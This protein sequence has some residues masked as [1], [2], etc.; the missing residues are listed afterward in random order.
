MS[1][2]PKSKRQ[3]VSNYPAGLIA[4]KLAGAKGAPFPEFI[5]PSLATAVPR[6]PSDSRWVHE[7]KFDGYRLQ[8]HL[9]AGQAT[10]YT[11]RGYDWTPR[12]RSLEEPIWHLPCHQVILDGEI[13]VPTEHGN[14]DFGALESDISK[15]ESDRMV[16]Y[17]FDLLHIDG[18]DLRGCKLIDR[19]SILE[20]LLE[21]AKPPMLVAEGPSMLRDACRLQLEGIV[22][23]RTDGRYM[24]GRSTNWSKVICR[25]R[26]TLVVAGLAYNGNKFDGIYLGR[27]GAGGISYAGKVE[28]GISA[29]Q[30]RDLVKRAKPLLTPRQVLTPTIKKA[31]ARWLKPKILVEVEYRALTGT[32]KVRHPSFKGSGRPVKRMAKN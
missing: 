26:E 27:R 29:E 4:A 32:G 11:R 19:K 12:F 1:R 9:K 16:F 24:S 10:F 30:Q 17:A 5:E 22:S 14:S 21:K 23:K 28:N 8:I 31:K 3:Y 15:G 25:K 18:F 7:I 20:K 6:P 13:I 2:V